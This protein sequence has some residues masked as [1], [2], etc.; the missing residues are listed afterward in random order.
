MKNKTIVTTFLVFLFVFISHSLI[1]DIPPRNVPQCRAAKKGDACKTDD[2]KPGKCL[3]GQCSRRTFNGEK[4][5]SE[6]YSCLVCE[7]E[8][9]PESQKKP[10]FPKNPPIGS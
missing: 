4:W 2:G 1:A 10:P 6:S 7:D 3:E 9:L 8:A 5:S